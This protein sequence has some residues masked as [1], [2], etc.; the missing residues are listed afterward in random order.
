MLKRIKKR[1]QKK[2]PVITTDS[3]QFRNMIII[4]AIIIITFVL[5]YFITGRLIKDADETNVENKVSTEIQKEKILVG[6]MF[7]RSDKEYY[8]LAYK[9]DDK[10]IDLYETYISKYNSDENNLIFYKI[11]LDE[12]LNKK[13]LS[14]KLNISNNL[15]E[16]KINDTILFKIVDGKVDSYYVGNNK[17]IEY[18][19]EINA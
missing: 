2:Q 18:L 13:Y 16:L 3:F 8:V 12:G 15:N 17:I 14:E 11:D 10:F 19:K 9:Q 6:Q 1:V 4:V 7:N 5:F